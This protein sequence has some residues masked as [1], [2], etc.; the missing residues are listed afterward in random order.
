MLM[1]LDTSD[2]RHPPRDPRPGPR[3]RPN[4]RRRRWLATLGGLACLLVARW[5]P[6]L[7]AYALFVGSLWLFT[8]AAV[9]LLP[10]GGDGLS[11][12]RQ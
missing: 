11:A 10:N 9:S 3:R 12:H 7:L 4:L 5:V 1:L 6:P 2:P 8:A